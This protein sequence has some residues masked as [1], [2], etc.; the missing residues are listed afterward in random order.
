MLFFLVFCQAGIQETR[1]P[2]T[3]I[4]CYRISHMISYRT[5]ICMLHGAGKCQAPA[6]NYISEHLTFPRL[7]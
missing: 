5:L 3:Y 4:C 6:I 7:I 1:P 2:I